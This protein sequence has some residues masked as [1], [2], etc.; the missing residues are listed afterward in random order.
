[1]IARLDQK[2]KNAKYEIYINFKHII[3]HESIM[4]VFTYDD[5]SRMRVQSGKFSHY[6]VPN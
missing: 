6:I 5:T 3:L 2:T 4:N 1:M